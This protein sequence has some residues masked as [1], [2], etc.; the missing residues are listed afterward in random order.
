GPISPRAAEPKSTMSP[1]YYS[2]RKARGV[3]RTPGTTAIRH[4]SFHVV[5]RESATPRLSRPGHSPAVGGSAQSARTPDGGHSGPRRPL[6]LRG[7]GG[8][9]LVPDG[10]LAQAGGRSLLPHSLPIGRGW[11]ARAGVRAGRVTERAGCA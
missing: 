7:D 4:G 8:G 3:G 2:I 5:L 10:G 1:R 9:P 11:A 6:R